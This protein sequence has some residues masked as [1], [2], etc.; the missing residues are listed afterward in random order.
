MSYEIIIRKNAGKEL[1]AIPRKIQESIIENIYDLKENARPDGCK[2][3]SGMEN[4]WRIRVGRYRVIYSVYDDIL[5]IE[6]I[7]IGHR[8]DIYQ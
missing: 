8:K 4:S 5:V 6:V 2:K 7:K 1:K 3:L